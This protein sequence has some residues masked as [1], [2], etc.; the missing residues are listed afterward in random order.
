[1][2]LNGPAFAFAPKSSRYP[3]VQYNPIEK[4]N[5]ASQA[6]DAGI[7]Y[8]NYWNYIYLFDRVETKWN[9]TTADNPIQEDEL[10]LKTV[11]L[12]EI[13]HTLGLPHHK[14]ENSVMFHQTKT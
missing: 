12:H 13:G 3:F 10:D 5:V 6:I 9:Y 7:I 1:M 8:E 11:V 4:N 2:A 14:D